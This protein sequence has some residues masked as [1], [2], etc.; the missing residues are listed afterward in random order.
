M[1]KSMRSHKK[2]K[3]KKRKEEELTLAA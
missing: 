1:F 2:K 3:R